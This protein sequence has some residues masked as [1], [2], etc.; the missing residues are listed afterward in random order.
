MGLVNL[1][2]ANEI[3]AKRKEIYLYYKEMLQHRNMTMQLIRKETEYNYCY[4]PLSSIRKP[5]CRRLKVT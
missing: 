1:K 5:W 3:L 2:Y 4:F